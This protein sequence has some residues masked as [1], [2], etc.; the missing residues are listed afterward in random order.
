MT[1]CPIPAAQGS[2]RVRP[3]R[4]LKPRELRS[5][6]APAPAPARTARTAQMH[7][8]RRVMAPAR[9]ARTARWGDGRDRWVLG[10]SSVMADGGGFA[11]WEDRV[12]HL[13]T[14]GVDVPA[15]LFI[16]ARPA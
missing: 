11:V 12:G 3:G 1:P 4:S 10:G 15:S 5:A 14:G 2:Q 13:R 6:P 9:A 8:T 7:R 16:A